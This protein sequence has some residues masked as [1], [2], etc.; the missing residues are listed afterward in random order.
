MACWKEGKKGG[1]GKRQGLKGWRQDGRK[2][3]MKDGRNKQTNKQ[4]ADG[5]EEA[6]VE[7][8]KET[9]RVEVVADV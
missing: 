9:R 2:E 4:T 7:G 3:G 6:K 1:R 5:W 8:W